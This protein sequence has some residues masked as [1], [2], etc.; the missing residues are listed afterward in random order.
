MLGKK[1]LA[2]CSILTLMF[3]MSSI[4]QDV[5][6]PVLYFDASNN[7][8]HPDA[9]TNLGTAGGEV[10]RVGNV[11]FEPA[12]DDGPARYT[13]MEIGGVFNSEDGDPTVH[14]E[15]WT[16][17]MYCKNNGP[18]F[19]DEEQLFAISAIPMQLVQAIR[20]WIDSDWIVVGNGR[21]GLI[22]KGK[23]TG[24]ETVP[25]NTSNMEIGQKE[26][27]WIVMVY[28]DGDRTFEGYLDGE[29]V[30]EKKTNQKF[31]PKLDMPIVRIFAG[32]GI[33]RNF[34]GSVSI[35]RVYDQALSA[36]QISP[37]FRAVEP[38]SKLAI[39]WGRV[40]ARS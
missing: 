25:S 29:L 27:H 31:D 13:S 16:I 12:G 34:N 4:A 5:P 1:L 22:I 36:E 38:T 37:N 26:W 10:E 30:D 7:P 2:A 21:T 19:G 23:D 20:A 17:E 9:W 18:K 11:Q 6:A 32:D 3:G 39:T 40:K 15:D 28:N 14:L 8:A 24:Q 35:F 33:G